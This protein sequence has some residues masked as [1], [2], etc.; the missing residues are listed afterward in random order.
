MSIKNIV[1]ILGLLSILVGGE[2]VH[3]ADDLRVMSFNVR[4]PNPDDG[5]NVWEKRRDTLVQTVRNF[6]PDVMGTQEIF[7]KQA[8]YIVRMLP[9]YKWFGVDRFGGHGNEHMGIFYNTRHITLSEHGVFW[10]SN[11]P[12]IPG[13]IGWGATLP[14]YV[15]WGVFE[16]RKGGRAGTRFLFL[17]THFANRDVEDAPARAH[18]VRLILEKLPQLA[19]GLPI[20]LV[21][22]FNSAPTDEAHRLMQKG[23]ID[24]WENA[25]H[26]EGPEG[27]FHDFTGTPQVMLDYVMTQGFQARWMKVDT[28]HRG[29]HYPSDHFPVEAILRMQ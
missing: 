24:M 7:V 23:L 17:D 3:A 16:E 18:S 28:A 5:V 21:G 15:N 29:A 12:N 20:I 8:D 25:A 11:T 22:D 19:H 26:K 9:Q 10:L 4:Y 1:R 6:S 13:S 14:R 27:T 2:R